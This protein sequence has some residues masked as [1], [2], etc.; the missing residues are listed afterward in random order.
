VCYGSNAPEVPVNFRAMLFGSITL[1]F[2]L[3]YDLTSQDR[4]W[5]LA[6]LTALLEAG[7]LQHSIGPRFSLDQIVQAHER[8][9]AGQS[10]GNVVLDL[11]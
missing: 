8:V 11:I 1:K 7:Q 4:A 3:V 10:V 9:E 6:Q 2:F 5:G